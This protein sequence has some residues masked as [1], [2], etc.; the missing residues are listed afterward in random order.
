MFFQRFIDE[1]GNDVVK[2]VRGNSYSVLDKF[3][4]MEWITR[5][6]EFLTPDVI[7]MCI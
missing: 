6:V 5:Y 2:I 4:A 7:F 1:Q 3:N